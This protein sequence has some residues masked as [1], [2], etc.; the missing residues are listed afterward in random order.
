MQY[1]FKYKTAYLENLV[2][3]TPSAKYLFSVQVEFS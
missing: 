3:S 2:K 1:E